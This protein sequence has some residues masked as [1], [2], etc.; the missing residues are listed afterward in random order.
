MPALLSSWGISSDILLILFGLGALQVII[1]S[2]GGI[3]AQV[4]KDLARLGGLLRRGRPV[5]GKVASVSEG[6]AK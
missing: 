4:P 3:S 5:S 6:G 1:T 2:P